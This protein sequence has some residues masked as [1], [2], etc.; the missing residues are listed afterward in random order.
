MKQPE[1]GKLF[2]DLVTVRVDAK[3]EDER[4]LLLHQA[5]VKH[6]RAASQSSVS[7]S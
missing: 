7:Q 6:H 2:L 4:R 5:G 3:D 1:V